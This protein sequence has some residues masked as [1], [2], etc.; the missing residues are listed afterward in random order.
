MKRIIF[1]LLLVPSLSFAWGEQ[2]HHTVCEVATRLIKDPELASFMKGKMH[3]M[4]HACNVP[5]IHWRSLGPIA[6]SGDA[7][8][9]LNPENLSYTIATVPTDFHQIFSEKQGQYSETLKR[10]IDVAEDLGSSWWRYDQFDRR[11][12]S[13][14]KLAKN[15]E[16]EISNLS[17]EDVK[18]KEE[19]VKFN[20]AIYSMLTNMG[21]MGHFVGDAS[22][23]FHN[24]TDYDGWNSGHGGIHAF[25]ET[26]VVNELS[27]DLADD[28]YKA[29]KHLAREQRNI[30]ATA[31]EKIRAVALATAQDLEKV[32]SLD[33]VLE[34]SKFIQNSDGTTTK[35]S[36]KRKDASEVAKKFKSIIVKEMALSALALA[37]TW[38]Q[39]YTDSGKPNFKYYSSFEYPLAPDFVAPDY[40]K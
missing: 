2:G 22:Q 25:Y 32:R 35:T 39:I 12:K 11:A 5:D 38:D 9:F 29:A 24:N 10:N 8:H 37:Q 4:G 7:T 27:L 19:T 36:A 6:K 14:G 17:K 3:M 31:I 40:I 16:A 30:P 1:A 18:M 28:V 23:P 26:K 20:S 34:S 15:I 21:L 33:R 13:D